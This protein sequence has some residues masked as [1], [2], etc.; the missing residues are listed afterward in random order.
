M[1]GSTDRG[2]LKIE[3]QNVKTAPGV[4]LSSHQKTIVG[5]VLDLFAG[6]PSLAKLGLWKDEATFADPITI[7]E[8]RAKYE[9]QWYGLQSA[10]SEIERLS[11][12][13][14]DAGNPIRMDMETRYVVKGLGKEQIIKSEIEIWMEGDKISKVADKWDGKLPDSGIANVSLLNPFTWWRYGEGWTFYLWSFVWETSLWR[15]S[16]EHSS[17]FHPGFTLALL[18]CIPVDKTP[19]NCDCAA[20][21]PAS[22]RCLCTKDDWGAQERRGGSPEGQ[23]VESVSERLNQACTSNTARIMNTSWTRFHSMLSLSL[24]WPAVATAR[25]SSSNPGICTTVMPASS[26]FLFPWFTPT[27]VS[28]SPTP[29]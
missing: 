8:G 25:I 6:R 10:F 7:A 22:K 16:V 5:S 1:S 21:F 14:K 3:S 28:G 12:E 2:E 29:V 23:P 13:V 9:A 11:H 27:N 17:W 15:V 4:E 19:A 18:K 20:G 26:S 24:T